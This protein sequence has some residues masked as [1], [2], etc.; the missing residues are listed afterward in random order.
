[1]QRKCNQIQLKAEDQ[2]TV[3]LPFIII[4]IVVNFIFIRFALEKKKK[5]E[6]WEKN[7]T[8]FN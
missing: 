8:G 4:V 3:S 5:H 2:Y 1:M 7:A 6:E